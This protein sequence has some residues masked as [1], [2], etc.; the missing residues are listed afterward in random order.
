MRFSMPLLD[1]T[2]RLAVPGQFGG[3]DTAD[4]DKER[5]SHADLVPLGEWLDCLEIKTVSQDMRQGIALAFRHVEDVT[6]LAFENEESLIGHLNHV[7]RLCRP[8]YTGLFSPWPA[9]HR[10]TDRLREYPAMGIHQSLL[11]FRC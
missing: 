3:G 9:L 1:I 4:Q 8:V 11:S 2:A 7:F 5:I 10:R 6:E